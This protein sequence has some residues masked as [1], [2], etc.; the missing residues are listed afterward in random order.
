M[1]N[2]LAQIFIS[3][4]M[5]DV[6]LNKQVGLSCIG[7]VFFR[8]V[9]GALSHLKFQ[10]VSQDFGEGRAGE[11]LAAAGSA[12]V[13]V[14]INKHSFVGYGLL[15]GGLAYLAAHEAAHA[16]KAMQAFN[17][18]QFE[19]YR[20]GA[21]KGLSLEV[22]K[23]QFPKSAEFAENEARANAIARDILNMLN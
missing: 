13:P 10:V 4:R 16:L 11:N 9:I 23:A 21:G 14:R 20:N 18:S 17:A 5:F 2:Q 15:P 22:Q 1:Q 19:L 8:D 3:A 7:A 12:D 6:N